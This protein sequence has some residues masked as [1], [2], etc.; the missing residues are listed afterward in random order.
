M[1]KEEIIK[2]LMQDNPGA[3]IDEKMT[4]QLDSIQPI[5][6]DK[7]IDLSNHPP[8][9]NVEKYNPLEE[10]NTKDKVKAN[11]EVRDLVDKLTP[12]STLRIWH[13]SHLKLCDP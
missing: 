9:I 11:N 4:K 1:S 5:P 3:Y 10:V 12:E 2:K 13:L 8:N 6:E 7:M